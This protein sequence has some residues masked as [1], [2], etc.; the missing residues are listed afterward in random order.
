[1]ENL[2]GKRLGNYYLLKQLGEGGFSSVYLGEHIHLKKLAAVKVLH[3]QLASDEIEKFLIAANRSAH[4]ENPNIVRVL[5]FGIAGNNPFLV[6]DYAPYGSLRQRHPR[7]TRVPFSAIDSYVKQ[8]AV[9]L[10]NAHDQRLIH[11]DLKPENI[12]VKNDSE[13][14]LSDFGIAV[15]AN[16]KTSNE[17]GTFIGTAEYMAP[18]QW[19]GNPQP[20]SDQYALG[21]VVYEWLTG[22]PPF[23][24]T[25]PDLAIKHCSE[26]PP[27]LHVKLP[28]VPT[29][30][31][32]AILKALAKNPDDR[33]AS[34]QEFAWALNQAAH[35]SATSLSIPMSTVQ[36]SSQ[37]KTIV[38]TVFEE[39]NKVLVGKIYS[40]QVG[41]AHMF[42]EEMYK[43]EEDSPDIL[44]DVSL[45]PSKNIQIISEK[46]QYLLY[47][48]NNV[49]PQFV[50]FEFQV[51]EPG[52][53][54]LAVDFYHERRWLKTIRLE[55]EA[56]EMP[57]AISSEV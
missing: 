20:A 23:Q 5:D 39:G 17:M 8:V 19:E 21:A 51:I 48:P 29:H 37:F 30:V 34:V 44:F 12:L 18:E 49:E 22:Q 41:I 36:P 42:Q 56:S 27:P 6:T 57:F 9:P 31:E 25:I 40:V 38:R 14:L 54:D 53:S 16:D 3:T 32:Q 24:G 52:R 46:Y 11:R 45:H 26:P 50:N 35:L 7:G 47:D 28:S 13:I 15:I 1:M 2:T 10:Q 55:C 4:L 43:E 33:F